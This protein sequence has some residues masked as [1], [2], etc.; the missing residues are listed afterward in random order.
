MF[1]DRTAEAIR[2]E[3]LEDLRQKTGV[4][5]VAGGFTD[6]MLGRAAVELSKAYQALNAV[7]SILFVD[8]TSGG[9][10][11]LHGWAY[12]N[13]ARKDGTRA[14]A[15]LTFE[16]TPG[17]VLPAGTAFVTEAGLEFSLLEEVT[18]D[19]DG[20]GRG[21][22][23]AAQVG[24][25]YNVAAGAI[26]RMYVNLPGLSGWTSAAAAG[27]TDGE[28][29]AALYARLDE[30]R[31]RPPTSGNIYHYRQWAMEVAGVGAVKVVPCGHGP[32]TVDVMVVD[33][34][35][36]TAVDEL[37]AQV[38]A[39]I[40]AERP[41]GAEVYVSTPDSVPVA[42]NAT[43]VLAEGAS[44]TAVRTA[45]VSELDTYLRSVVREKYDAIY[46]EKG[47]DKP[48]RVLY[49][50]VA[51]LL[52]TVEGVANYTALTLN[53]AAQDITLTPEQVPVRGEVS[54]A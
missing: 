9:F 20:T 34:T 3:M 54:V 47:Q 14:R 33:G 24:A 7:P 18:L 44:L 51:T 35:M 39:H 17:A 52:M 4:T 10:L 53:G 25:A 19:A 23:E 16:G 29:D 1:E 6:T 26:T 22:V 31:K 28:S 50:R 48:Y 15:T 37:V 12:F 8:E 43:V 42:V 45:L 41:I 11:D 46:G 27:G 36:A 2:A 32:G 38:A 30:R 13:L 40:E 49:N 21:T 5:A